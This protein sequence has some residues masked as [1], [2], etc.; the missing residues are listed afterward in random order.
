MTGGTAVQTCRHGFEVASSLCTLA[1]KPL[2]DDRPLLVESCPLPKE[3]GRM[4]D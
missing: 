2:E 4:M 3:R 1:G